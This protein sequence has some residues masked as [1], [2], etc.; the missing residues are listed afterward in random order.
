MRSAPVPRRGIGAQC[1]VAG[2]GPGCGSRG[3][4]R[5]GDGHRSRPLGGR[6]GDRCRPSA[7]GVLPGEFSPC[8]PAHRVPGQRPVDSRCWVLG[9]GCWVLGAG[10]WARA[11]GGADGARDR[12]PREPPGT[13]GAVRSAQSAAG[14]VP[15]RFAAA[16]RNA[17]TGAVP[18]G[19]AVW[20]WMSWRSA[21]GCNHPRRS[22]RRAVVHRAEAPRQA[23]RGMEKRR[24][25]GRSV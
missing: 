21:T 1:T 9:A 15:C 3:R 13:V 2:A 5:G 16:H 4:R 14:E 12:P 24:G 20:R 7:W 10:C 25:T 23:G 18:A 22:G 6:R 8:T 17:S 19:R 11:S